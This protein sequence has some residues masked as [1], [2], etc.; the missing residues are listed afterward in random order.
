MFTHQQKKQGTFNM[1][2]IIAIKK[3]KVPRNKQT[4]KL[5]KL[6]SEIS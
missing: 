6:L 5:S 4:I 1:L 2:F 3:Y